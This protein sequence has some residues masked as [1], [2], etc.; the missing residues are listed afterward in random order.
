[1]APRRHSP[2]R[3]CE[4]CRRPL[5]ADDDTRRARLFESEGDDRVF[6]VHAHCL[7]DDWPRIEVGLERY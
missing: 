4:I 2:A 7:S 5:R 3:V 1:M 6:V